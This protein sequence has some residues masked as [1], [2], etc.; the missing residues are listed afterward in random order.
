MVGLPLGKKIIDDMF[1][2][3]VSTIP[4]CGGRTDRRTDRRLATA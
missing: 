3:A 1:S 2:S 4:A